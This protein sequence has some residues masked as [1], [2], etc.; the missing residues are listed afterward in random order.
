[1]VAGAAIGQSVSLRLKDGYHALAN[2]YA[3]I[4]CEAGNAKTKAISTVVEP[5]RQSDAV[6]HARWEVEKA[7]FVALNDAYERACKA[8]RKAPPKGPELDDPDEIVDLDDETTEPEPPAIP[9]KP[10]PPVWKRSV[11][12]DIT[13]ESMT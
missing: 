10:V 11:V 6:N 2:L 9:A 13:I 8:A 12:V 1:M 5:L 7:K 4:V 3:M